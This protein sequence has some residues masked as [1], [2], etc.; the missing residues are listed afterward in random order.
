MPR[1]SSALDDVKQI[2]ARARL[3]HAVEIRLVARVPSALALHG[4]VGAISQRNRDGGASSKS[5]STTAS[6]YGEGPRRTIGS[7]VGGTA[8]GCR[9][10]R[11]VAASRAQG[12]ATA[13]DES[14]DGEGTD[15]RRR[16][17]AQPVVIVVP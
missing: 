4:G 9:R 8:T 13:R 5:G 12:L 17:A 14:A 6:R 3:K 1:A 2:A 10:S 16:L 11:S 15:K 7:S